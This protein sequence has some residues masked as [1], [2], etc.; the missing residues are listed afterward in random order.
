[1][2]SVLARGD[3]GPCVCGDEIPILRIDEL[4]AEGL[5][6]DVEFISWGGHAMDSEAPMV[7]RA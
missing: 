1:L 5:D 7:V 4:S 3:E 2:D 6:D